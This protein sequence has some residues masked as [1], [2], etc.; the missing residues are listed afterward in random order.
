MASVKAGGT[1][2]SCGAHS[3]FELPT[4]SFRLFVDS[5]SIHG[6]YVGSFH[7]FKDLISYVAAKGIK[8]FIGKIFPL[9]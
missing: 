3:G 7:K 4:D 8:P 6:V 1:I 2:V 9:S 5:L